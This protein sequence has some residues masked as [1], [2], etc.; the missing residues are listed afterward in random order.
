MLEEDENVAQAAA[1][2]I[3]QTGSSSSIPPLKKVLER[4]MNE[5][6]RYQI[7]AAIGKCGD[8]N[9]NYFLASNYNVGKD[10]RGTAWA[11]FYLSRNEMINEA[12]I[13]LAVKIIENEKDP[14]TRLG[15]AQA[16]ARSVLEKPWKSLLPLYKIEQD[17]DVQMALASGLRGLAIDSLNSSLIE[18]LRSNSNNTQINFIKAVAQ[19]GQL[20]ISRILYKQYFFE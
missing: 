20:P 8:I 15:A 3:G 4:S 14:R 6:T 19:S 1:F 18:F 11:L 13:E 9:E 7:F 10:A 12:G 5:E 17:D 16:I 2:A